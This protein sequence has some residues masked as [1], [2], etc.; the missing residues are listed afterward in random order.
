MK[1]YPTREQAKGLTC[2]RCKARPGAACRGRRGQDR[3]QV[4]QARLDAV[5]TPSWKPALPSTS[6][7]DFVP[8]RLVSP[9]EIAATRSGNGGWTKKQLAEWG[10]PWPPPKGWRR[11][12]EDGYRLAKSLG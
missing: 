8:T 9:E 5:S 4:H 11:R 7:C 10:V 1:V 3:I 6:T 2:P 12:L